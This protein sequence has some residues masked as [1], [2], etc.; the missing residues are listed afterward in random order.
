MPKY[1]GSAPLR[2]NVPLAPYT[3]LGVGGPARFMIDAV[4]ENQISA[5]LKFALIGNWPVFVLGGGSNILVSDEGFPGVVIRI[6]LRGIRIDEEGDRV[7]ITAAAGEE[8]DPL[9]KWCIGRDLAGIECLSGIPG[10][11]GGTP[12]QNVGAY[13][14]EVCEVIE[15]VRVLDRRTLRFK[16]FSNADCGFSYRSSI[17]NSSQREQHIV[18]SVTYALSPDGTACIQYADL[19]RFFAGK[20]NRPSLA[21]TRE[22]VLNI[23]AAKA[24]VL[25]AGD[26]DCKSAGSFFKN[27]IVSEDLAKRVEAAARAHRKLAEAEN[28]PSYTLGGGMVK[29]P[30]AWL[31]ERAGFTKGYGRG[32][33]GLSRK[34]TLAI[35]NRGNASAKDILDLAR[36]IQF[37]VKSVFSVD[38]TPEPILVGF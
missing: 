20:V 33:A 6:A 35:I 14:Q 9:V 37:G 13:G 15:H 11:V 22:V 27:P 31:I 29:L 12:V 24:M 30:A 21:E 8:W 19:Q 4:E 16:D 23:R 1:S 38:L 34:H 28:L 17:F 18:L 25:T 26:P 2:E 3:T 36:E 10:T 7:L 32:G 5:A